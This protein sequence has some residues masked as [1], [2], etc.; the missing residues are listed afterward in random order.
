MINDRPPDPFEKPAPPKP[1][2]R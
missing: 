1:K 2:R